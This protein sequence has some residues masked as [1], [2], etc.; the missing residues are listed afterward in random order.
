MGATISPVIRSTIIHRVVHKPDRSVAEP[1]PP[2]LADLLTPLDPEAD[3]FLRNHIVRSL[4][5]Q[6]V[7]R[8]RFKLP[9]S[10]A[11]LTMCDAALERPDDDAVFIDQSRAIAMALAAAAQGKFRPD[12]RISPGDLVVCLV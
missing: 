9:D 8:G 5:D 1:L 6:N 4:E 7:R 2:I 12:A 11:I 10:N 3:A